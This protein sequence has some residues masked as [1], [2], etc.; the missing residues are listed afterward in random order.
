MNFTLATKLAGETYLKV[1]GAVGKGMK[2]ARPRN[3]KRL[4]HLTY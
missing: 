3:I 2:K 4:K 1:A